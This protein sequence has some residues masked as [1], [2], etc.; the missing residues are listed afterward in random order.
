MGPFDI[1]KKMGQS[2]IVPETYFYVVSEHLLVSSDE[3]VLLEDKEERTKEGKW[4]GLFQRK[5]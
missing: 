5:K 2:E 1:F 3:F 4:K